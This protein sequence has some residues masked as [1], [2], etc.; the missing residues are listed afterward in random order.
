MGMSKVQDVE[1]MAYEE[2]FA[3]LET[4]VTTL[5]STQCSLE[6]A[7]QLYERGQKLSKRCAELLNQAE[8][9]INKLSVGSL[10]NKE[11]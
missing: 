7:I 6:E 11:A 4:I 3:E 5:E 2:A 9:K 1:K 10:D 8:I